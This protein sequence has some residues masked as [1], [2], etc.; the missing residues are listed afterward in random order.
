MRIP[1]LLPLALAGCGAL[2]P[3]GCECVWRPAGVNEQNLAVMA[4]RPAERVLGTGEER[5]AG[6]AA[7]GAVERLRADRV[8]PLPDIGVARII[9]LPGA[10]PGGG[11]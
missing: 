8:K 1:L 10:A 11:N 4:A 3:Y 5:A 9:T 6:A 7:A 2:D